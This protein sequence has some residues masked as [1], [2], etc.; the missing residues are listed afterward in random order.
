MAQR[1]RFIGMLAMLATVF[2]SV[3]LNPIV[4]A[5]PVQD[6]PLA[7]ITNNTPYAARGT[8]EYASV[9]CSNDDY[10]VD[11]GATWTASS[12]GVCLITGIT[13]SLT[14]ADDAVA[15]TSTGTSYAKFFI[16]P[17]AGDA[18]YRVFSESEYAQYTDKSQ[19]ESPGF[20]IRNQTDW[21]LAIGLNQ[22]GCLYQ[23]VVDKGGV[24]VRDT[25]SVWF[26]IGVH[27][28]PDGRVPSDWDCVGTAATVVGGALFAASEFGFGDIS[29]S[30]IG[31]EATTPRSADDER[32]AAST[33]VFVSAG[34]LTGNL[35]S[36]SAEQIGN[37]IM[38][39]GRLTLTGQYAGYAW[40]FRCDQMP[41]YVVTGG[42]SLRRIDGKW[43]IGAGTPFTISKVNDC[44]DDMML[45][46][47]QS[48]TA[49]P[50]LSWPGAMVDMGFAAPAP[51]AT[52]VRAVTCPST[53]LCVAV[54]EDGATLTTTDGGATWRQGAR[55]TTQLLDGVAC[56]S[57][58]ICIATGMAGTLLTSADGGATWRPRTSGTTTFLHGLACP[59]ASLCLTVGLANILTS[60]D[61]GATWTARPNSS[62]EVLHGV[63][64]SSASLCMAVGFG[65]ILRSADGGRT[66]TAETGAPTEIMNSLACLDPNQCLG[67]GSS[68]TIV[69]ITPGGF[70]AMISRTT[71][72]LRGIACP[73]RGSVRRGG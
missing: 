27:I 31:E 14:G 33:S 55:R 58:S 22:A 51:A 23:G 41:E 5:A 69:K 28:Q 50:K 19:R 54:G 32:M 64:C 60:A 8:V 44:G 18:G 2:S 61:A 43:E 40:P 38:D 6:Y 56:P 12:R 7:T 24:F 45:A 20:Y 34:G 1:F 37:L 4:Q 49:E 13:A 17:R 59:S 30:D 62:T 73:G 3:T 29:F 42:P 53:S 26:T 46:S 9:F 68:G 10:V 36:F 66:W 63:A 16:Y 48:A 67:V 21:P 35:A 52:G 57:P 15:Y 65:T 70:G 47:A 11:P 71:E 25:G 72:V 39:N